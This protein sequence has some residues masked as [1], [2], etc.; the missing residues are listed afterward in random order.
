MDACRQDQVVAGP[1]RAD[2]VTRR[3][4]AFTPPALAAGARA[5]SGFS[6][7][8]GT[9]CL[10]ALNLC[11]DCPGPLSGDQHADA[12]VIADVAARWV[13]Q[14]QAGAPLDAVAGGAGDR[15]RLPLGGA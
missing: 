8:V 11:R 10:G 1:G 2:P 13:L 5:V 9:V 15:R 12:L 14:A 4:R 7:R 3:W 6:L